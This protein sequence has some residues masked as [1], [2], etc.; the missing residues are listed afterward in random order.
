M[1]LHIN[2]IL[3]FVTA[4]LFKNSDK[5]IY[6]MYH[7]IITLKNTQDTYVTNEN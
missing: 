6:F 7:E 3:L 5:I 1:V 4:I 2:I